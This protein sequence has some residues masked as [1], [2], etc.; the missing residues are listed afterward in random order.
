[1]IKTERF[2]LSANLSIF[3]KENTM[4]SDKEKYQTLDSPEVTGLLFHPRPESGRTE[5]LQRFQELSI[6]VDAGVEISGRFYASDKNA[7]VLLF[8]HGNGE[9]VEDYDDIGQLYQ[10]MNVNFIPIDYR[11]YG[12]STGTPCI[13]NMIGDSYKIFDFVT[14]QLEILG[15]TGALV[16]MGRSLG[17]APALELVSQVSDRI[18]GLILESGFSFS[19]PLLRLLGINVDASGL[20]EEEGFCNYLKI[21]DFDKPTLIIHAELDHIIPFS[22]GDYLYQKSPDK[23][24]KL[25]KIPGANH[26]DIL[27]RGLE[28]Y[29]VAVK[30]LLERVITRQ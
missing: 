9:I 20:K 29:M 2:D 19:L 18:D 5:E 8:F 25:L 17:S 11:G 27:S 3:A 1:L 7:P 16:V 13:S 4:V 26:N 12:R 28:S 15:Y 10:R 24:K 22:D 21:V 14:H 23:G 6:P 30:A